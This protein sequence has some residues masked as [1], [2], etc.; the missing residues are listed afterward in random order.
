MAVETA[1]KTILHVLTHLVNPWLSLCVSRTTAWVIALILKS[2]HP[3]SW[4]HYT[5]W[6][7]VSA[8]LNIFLATQCWKQMCILLLASRVQTITLVLHEITTRTPSLQPGINET[9]LIAFFSQTCVARVYL[10]WLT[11]SPKSKLI[12]TLLTIYTISFVMC[13]TINSAD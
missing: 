12:R 9:S 11:I 10:Y 8:T 13:I 1:I 5:I 3:E 2:V 7:V 6:R 4:Y